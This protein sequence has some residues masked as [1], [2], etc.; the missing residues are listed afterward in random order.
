MTELTIEQ[1]I[2]RQ[3]WTFRVVADLTGNQTKL[4]AVMLAVLGKSRLGKAFGRTA[5]IDV[6]GRVISD[7]VE[8]GEIKGPVVVYDNVADFRDDIMRLVE[9]LEF[10]DEEVDELFR[11][12]QSWISRDAYNG[13]KGFRTVHQ[14]KVHKA[15]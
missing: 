14:V 7:L 2:A 12:V 4:G 13:G 5:T 3:H 15:K 10:N 11:K 6:N 1:Q 8:E 9:R